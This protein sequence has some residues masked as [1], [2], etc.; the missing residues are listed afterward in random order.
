MLALWTTMEKGVR[1][2]LLVD[3]KEGDKVESAVRFLQKPSTCL[4]TPRDSSP[5]AVEHDA[6]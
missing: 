2:R 4:N 6:T 1:V 5:E 3:R